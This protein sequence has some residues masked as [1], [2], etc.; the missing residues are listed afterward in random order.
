MASNPIPTAY[1]KSVEITDSAID[2]SYHYEVLVAGLNVGPVQE[3]L[4][5]LDLSNSLT[6]S[7]IKT[8]IDNAII[9][10]FASAKG[11][12]LNAAHIFILSDLAG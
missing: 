10:M 5:A 3:D 12:T 11:V 8:A 9:A 2:N 1:V 4:V 6:K 7:Q